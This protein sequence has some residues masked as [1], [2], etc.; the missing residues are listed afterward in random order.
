MV[1]NR[2]LWPAELLMLKLS[3]ALIALDVALVLLR[4]VSFDTHRYGL[5]FAMAAFIGAIGLAYRKSGRSEAI[6]C[7][8]IAFGLL[9]AFSSALSALNYLL[10]PN[11]RPA[12][13]GWLARTDALFGYHWPDAIALSARYP[14][15]NELMRW[16]YNSTSL[17]IAL[18]AVAL[19]LANRRCSLHAMVLTVALSSLATV[20]FWALF[21]SLGPSALHDLPADVLAAVHPVVNPAYGEEIT[22]LMREGITKLSPDEFR[23]LIAFPSFH[24]IMALIATWY[25]RELRW[26]LYPLLSVNLFILPAVL[27][28]GGHHLIDIPAGF[29]VF[30]LAVFVAGRMVRTA[31]PAPAIEKAAA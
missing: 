14:V 11:R 30:T 3:A 12:I 24:T 17:Q 9:V 16:S 19:G 31:H 23:G 10:L 6:A 8:G 29:A 5:T 27:V 28:H 1:K 13:D 26:L 20:A 18:V 4:G 22:R 2:F 21:P 25:A 15:V 7:T